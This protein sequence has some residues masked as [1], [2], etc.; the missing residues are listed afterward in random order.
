MILQGMY[1]YRYIRINFI[2]FKVMAILLTIASSSTNAQLPTNFVDL[3]QSHQF[4]EDGREQFEREI[5]NFPQ[6]LKLPKISLPKDY[7]RKN[8][9]KQKLIKNEPRKIQSISNWA[10]DRYYIYS[11][12]EL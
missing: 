1:M 8:Q 2:I 4:F 3:N 9:I 10:I 7:N 12:V 5:D 11:V 6:A